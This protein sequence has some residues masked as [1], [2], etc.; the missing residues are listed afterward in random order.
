MASGDITT[1][2]GT[3]TALTITLNSVSSGA[4]T[5]ASNAID[6]AGATGPVT[7]VLVELTLGSAV[8]AGNKQAIVY[9][10]SSVDG[11]NFGDAA[12]EDNLIRIGTLNLPSTAAFRSQAFSIA[13][14]YRVL[15]PQCKIVVKNDAGV[16]FAGSGNSMQYRFVYENV[17]P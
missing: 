8:W 4:L 14:A 13:A 9:V 11:T 16:A 12:N 10:V 1:K 3:A 5:S 7:D 2:Y 6:V 17:A 15:P